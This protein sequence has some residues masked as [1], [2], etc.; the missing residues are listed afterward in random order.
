MGV[1]KSRLSRGSNSDNEGNS[2]TII[3]GALTHNLKKTGERL[4]LLEG[5]IC[6][7]FIHRDGK[8]F[9]ECMYMGGFALDIISYQVCAL[10]VSSYQGGAITKSTHP[11]ELTLGLYA[12]D[13]D[14][15]SVPAPE[16]KTVP[17]FPNMRV[18]IIER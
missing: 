9:I 5:K 7:T 8:D 16:I 18:V 1:S 12:E 14:L 4:Y 10:G 2:V 6:L 17:C 11:T 13:V 15:D 3:T